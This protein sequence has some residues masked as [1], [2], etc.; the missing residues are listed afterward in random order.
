MYARG[1]SQRDISSTIE[2]IYGF[3]VSHEMVSDIT[4]TVL[5][6]LD[7][8]QSRPLSNALLKVLY[9]RTKELEN[10]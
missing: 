4:D 8:W 1:M 5:P 10:K 9:L 6:G 7:E 2:E 3:T